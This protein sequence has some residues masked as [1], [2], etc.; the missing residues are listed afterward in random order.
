MTAGRPVIDVAEL[1]R[2]D[3]LV[4]SVFSDDAISTLAE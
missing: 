1:L 3:F 4:H 2:G